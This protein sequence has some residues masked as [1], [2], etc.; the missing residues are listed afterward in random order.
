MSGE[1]DSTVPPT[2][3]QC[4]T[5][6]DAWENSARHIQGFTYGSEHVIRDLRRRPG[7]QLIWSGPSDDREAFDRQIRVERMRLALCTTHPHAEDLDTHAA[8]PES[9]RAL[10]PK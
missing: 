4:L 6:A 2:D 1:E 5:I 9:C 3:A 7:Q 10:E 8:E